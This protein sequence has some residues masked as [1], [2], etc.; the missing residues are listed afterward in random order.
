MEAIIVSASEAARLL[1]TSKETVLGQLEAGII[2][3]YREGKN[4]KIPIASLEEY[5]VTRAKRETEK[6]RKR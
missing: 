2:P 1:A 5:A 3:G 6:R 4:W